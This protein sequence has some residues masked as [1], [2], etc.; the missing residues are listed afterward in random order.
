MSEEPGKG[1]GKSGKGNEDEPTGQQI[2]DFLQFAYE[3]PANS[4]DPVIRIFQRV[5]AS[6]YRH[7]R[8][9]DAQ[10]AEGYA[11]EEE[12]ERER[13]ERPER[14]FQELGASDAS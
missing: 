3:A 14:P 4:P 7:A 6:I 2:A 1:S 9:S 12:D 5:F 11:M 13:P 10:I 8:E